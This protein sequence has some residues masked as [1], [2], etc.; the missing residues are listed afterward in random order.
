M[1]SAIHWSALS[2]V[3]L[4]ACTGNH[5]T[6]PPPPS[7]G[8]A[9]VEVAPAAIT[10]NVKATYQLVATPRDVGGDPVSGVAVSWSSSAP[11]VATVSSTGLVTATSPG[12]STITATASG[13]QGHATVTVVSGDY[14]PIIAQADVGPAGGTIGNADVA[15]TIP[16]GV[17]TTTRTV[18]VIHD[19][20]SSAPYPENSASGLYFV[21]GLSPGL[22]S[23]S[24]VRIRANGSNSGV[25]AI[26]MLVPATQFGDSESTV[27]GSTLVAA[28]DSSGYLV[29]TLPLSGRVSWSG[30]PTGSLNL[31]EGAAS[32]ILPYAIDP[33]Q[34][35][36]DVELTGLMNL[37]H[38]TSSAGH[39]E[40]W[41]F[42]G[43]A[44]VQ[45]KVDHT[46]Q[47]AEQAY[48]TLTGMG[49]DL[50]FRA[51][52]P[53]QVYILS[54]HDNGLFTQP[55]PW[56]LDVTKG[57]ISYNRNYTGD[58]EYPGVVIHELFHLTKSQL[59]PKNN[60]A[61]LA[62]TRWL[63]EATSTWVQEKHPLIAQPYTNAV[64]EWLRDSMFTG[65]TS[66]MV[67][68]SGYGKAPMIKYVAKRWGDAKVKEAL[69]LV[70]G[71]MTTTS[72]FLASLPTQPS[73]WWPDLLD[74]YLA[75]TLYPWPTSELIPTH[76]SN[77]PL[78]LG[79]GAA[80]VTDPL[81][82]LGV[83]AMLIRRDT[84]MFGPAFQAPVYLKAST[85]GFGTILAY[86][87]TGAGH[88][89]RFAA[90]DTVLIP[91]AALQS[92]DSILLLLTP[93]KPVAPYSGWRKLEFYTDLRVP[94][95]DWYM[96]NLTNLQS[97]IAFSC[98]K[99]GNSVT[100]DVGSNATSIWN[101]LATTGVFAP[102]SVGVGNAETQT[103]APTP[104]WADSMRKYSITLQSTLT[105]GVALDTIRMQ[106]HL[107]L[108][109]ATGA[110]AIAEPARA[111]LGWWA[112]GLGLGALVL[113]L[114]RRTR[115]AGTA[116]MGV[117][118]LLLAACEIGQINFATDE[119]LD[120]TFT[121]MRF[122]ADPARPSDPLMLVY[123]GSGKTSMA[124][125]RS[126]YW[127]YTTDATGATTDS[128]RVVCTGSGTAT[129]VLDGTAY[130]D[131]VTPTGSAS[132]A[133]IVGHVLG[134][135][136]AQLRGALRIDHP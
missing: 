81:Y 108:N 83:H 97:S 84:A 47:L 43:G 118:L 62:P 30:G 104:A 114:R 119:T 26:A 129:Y 31:R 72:A 128:T 115:T 3:G 64:A 52:K 106:A 79:R 70:H 61:T 33:E 1:R 101:L 36:A 131:G 75:G 37:S 15:I 55:W 135:D 40:L 99:P 102:S 6:N 136:P 134:R 66:G 127:S 93:N 14:G 74:Q 110:G 120:L 41:G 73:E 49:Y 20:V 85:I 86:R 25:E 109:T 10:M 113:L 130:N 28:T 19:T 21:D 105:T 18:K 82:A 54:M 94:P 23:Q 96:S 9:T 53:I 124:S 44:D 103:W 59:F 5:S 71:G 35:K 16:A 8:V 68:W 22:V 76:R 77:L 98:D 27:M 111:G 122:T 123:A 11:A 56:P 60:W 133:D 80:W 2:V 38:A 63:D 91:G 78:D 12:S 29:A 13:K 116:L 45:A 125:Y 92:R 65:L 117:S 69:D 24:R 126:E 121:R 32:V 107:V 87:K 89:Q 100:M 4:L 7:S 48:S 67:G 46:A 42:G 34:L 58:A 39:F 88:F 90:G 132:A 112:L 17:M 57:Y 51:A 95:A 50:S